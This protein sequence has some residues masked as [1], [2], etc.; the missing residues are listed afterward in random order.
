MRHYTK[1]GILHELERRTGSD[2]E[3]ELAWS[4]D[5]VFAITRMRLALRFERFESRSPTAADPVSA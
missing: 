4:L 5:Q 3:A 2:T 1:A